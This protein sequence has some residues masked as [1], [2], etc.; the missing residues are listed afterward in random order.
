[1]IIKDQTKI[2]INF[3]LFIPIFEGIDVI[4]IK[5]RLKNNPS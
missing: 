2:I 3:K 4:N 5:D 1:M